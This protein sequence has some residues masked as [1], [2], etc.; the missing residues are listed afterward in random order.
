MVGHRQAWSWQDEWYGLTI[1]DIRELE[2]ETQ[3]ELS[4]RM[5]LMESG[6]S[7]PNTNNNQLHEEAQD[8]APSMETRGPRADDN[9]DGVTS[10]VANSL[11][12]KHR[13][14]SIQAIT[15]QERLLEIH[16]KHIE[17]LSDDGLDEDDDDRNSL[18]FDALG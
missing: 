6:N 17:Q 16:M 8:A 5:D 4:K 7:G 13:N 9:S 1:E 12:F 18:Y 11:N 2:K 10:S 3:L 15:N 14:S